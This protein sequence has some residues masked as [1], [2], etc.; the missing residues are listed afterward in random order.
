MTE[1]NETKI[2]NHL[3]LAIVS[4]CLSGL[5]AFFAMPAAVAS[6]I[7]A[8]RVDDK[9]KTDLNAAKQASKFAATFGWIAVALVI[10]PW[11]LIIFFW[12]AAGF[13]LFWF[14]R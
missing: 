5:G 1:N 3:V 13:G 6:L 10:I 9:I 12:L 7:F 14:L 2:E 11:L 8:L 4:L